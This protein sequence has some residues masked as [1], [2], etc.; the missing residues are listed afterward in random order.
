MKGR[1]DKRSAYPLPPSTH[2]LTNI[3]RLISYILILS[4]GESIS[5]CSSS[6]YRPVIR[7][8]YFT[9]DHFTTGP[10]INSSPFCSLFEP[11][12]I[13]LYL[14]YEQNELIYILCF[15]LRYKVFYLLQTYKLRGISLW[16]LDFDDF[17]GTFCNRGK[18]P[19]ASIVHDAV[20][21]GKGVFSIPLYKI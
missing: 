20:E 8:S 12:N 21:L 1:S 4:C 7:K 6:I 15:H 3:K 9:K 5:R 13:I 18:Y 10:N 14:V 19:I 16:A 17:T 2:I 11:S